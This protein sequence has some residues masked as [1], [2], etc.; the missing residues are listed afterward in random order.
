MRLIRQGDRFVA[1]FSFVWEV[2]TLAEREEGWVPLF[3][4]GH[5]EEPLGAIHSQTHK[6][7]LRQ[8]V[9]LA[10]RQIVVLGTTRFPEPPL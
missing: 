3:L 7:H 1:Q 10:E 5:L 2:S 9:R 8:G 6:V 4:P